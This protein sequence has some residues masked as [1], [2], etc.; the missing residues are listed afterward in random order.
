[1]PPLE[2]LQRL[3]GA[4]IELVPLVEFPRHYVFTRDGFVALVERVGDGFAGVGAPGLFTEKG[5]LAMLVWRDG[6][7]WFVAKNWERRATGDEVLS[8]RKFAADLA[9][10]LG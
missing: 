7:A 10:A 5:L 2:K 8:L 9:R 4:G 6:A 3:A 1:V